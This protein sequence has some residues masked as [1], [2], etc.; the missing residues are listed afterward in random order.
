MS[1]PV[2]LSYRHENDT[3]RAR[4]RHLAERLEKA[5]LT[6]VLDQFAQEREFY[7]GG[8]DQGWPSWSKGH[9]SNVDNMVLV[10]ASAGWF[11]CYEMK[12]VPGSGLGAAAEAGIIQQRIYNNAGVNSDIRI[13]T[14]DHLDLLTLPLDLQRYHYFRDPDDFSNLTH[15]L[16]GTTPVTA[17]AA[18]WPQQPP[19]LLWPVADHSPVRLAFERLLTRT[20]GGRF[21][22]VQGLSE[23]GKSHITQQML[24]NALRLTDLACGRFDFKGTIDVEAEIRAF[25]QNLDVPLPPAGRTLSE[26]FGRILKAL[27]QRARPA[28]LIFDT[29]EHAGDTQDWVEKQLLPGLIRAAWMR[30]VIAGQRVPQSAGTLWD[31]EACTPIRLASPPA[32]EW[33]AFSQ[34]YKPGV[35]IDFVRQAFDCC[36]GKAS[37]LTHFKDLHG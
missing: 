10:I 15:W 4:V 35:T 32:E 36:D 11:K 31:A 27:K 5:K 24:G 26:R 33:F 14:F 23:T 2:F 9:A 16:T 17:T 8:P 19:E 37:A 13:V 29:Y 6:I 22:S 20:P 34:P 3:H 25:V 28:L 12:E 21:L 1:K 30:L 7:G 18:D